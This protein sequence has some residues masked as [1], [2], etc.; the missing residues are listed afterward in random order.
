MPVGE[1]HVESAERFNVH[2]LSKSVESVQGNNR[3]DSH[4]IV[5]QLLGENL[6]VLDDK[7]LR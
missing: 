1:D 2:N 4:S 7:G 5:S 3:D 6:D